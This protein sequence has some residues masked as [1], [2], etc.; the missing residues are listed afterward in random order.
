M[1]KLH[2]RSKNQY[3]EAIIYN[4]IHRALQR[5]GKTSNKKILKAIVVEYFNKPTIISPGVTIPKGS[6][7]GRMPGI[8]FDVQDKNLRLFYP[9]SSHQIES[10]IKNDFVYV[11]FENEENLNSG[12]ILGR[13]PD[14]NSMVHPTGYI[15]THK[16]IWADNVILGTT[17]ANVPT[18]NP[19]FYYSG[20]WV[21]ASNIGTTPSVWPINSNSRNYEYNNLGIMIYVNNV[22]PV[23]VL[24]A[25]SGIIETLEPDKII[26]NH[27]EI[28]AESGIVNSIYEGIVENS[29]NNFSNI[30]LGSSV[31]TGQAIAKVDSPYLLFRITVGGNSVDPIPYINFIGMESTVNLYDLSQNNYYAPVVEWR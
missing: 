20:A 28:S 30:Q 19:T 5:E 9:K 2:R 13:V 17:K 10:Y 23:D 3:P 26:I 31:S 14:E 21:S 15:N 4:E 18:T 22:N 12:I 29:F 25:G 27:G 1:S 7:R 16:S 8:D 11:T 6:I 24:S